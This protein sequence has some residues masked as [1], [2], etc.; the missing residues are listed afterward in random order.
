MVPELIQRLHY[1]LGQALL[2]Q[3]EGVVRGGRRTLLADLFCCSG[4]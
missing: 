4:D 2:S 3:Q 1:H